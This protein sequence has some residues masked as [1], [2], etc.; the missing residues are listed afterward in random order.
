MVDIGL[1]V[2]YNYIEL[3]HNTHTHTLSLFFSLSSLTLFVPFFLLGCNNLQQ[4]SRIDRSA[5][6]KWTQWT[7]TGSYTSEWLEE[8]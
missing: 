5:H 6:T 1:I 8:N 2:Q 3:K 7:C 4:S